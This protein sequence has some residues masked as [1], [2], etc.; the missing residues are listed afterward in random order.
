MEWVLSANLLTYYIYLYIYFL[1]FILYFIS[2]VCL[3]GLSMIEICIFIVAL[4]ISAQVINSPYVVFC[5]ETMVTR[6]YSRVVYQLK[7]TNPIY[8]VPPKSPKTH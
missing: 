1:I 5:L 7:C 6:P 8:N 2:L 3:S 4:D